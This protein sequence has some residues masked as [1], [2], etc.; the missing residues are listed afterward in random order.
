MQMAAHA[1]KMEG[2]G[3]VTL[4]AAADVQGLK[5]TPWVHTKAGS[6]FLGNHGK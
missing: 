4:R 6:V 5:T 3:S 2:K 1:A